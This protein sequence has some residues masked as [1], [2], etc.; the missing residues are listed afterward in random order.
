MLFN[1]DEKVGELVENGDEATK[2][3]KKEDDPAENFPG[4]GEEDV[5]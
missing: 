1:D 5:E 2:E 4:N 3:S